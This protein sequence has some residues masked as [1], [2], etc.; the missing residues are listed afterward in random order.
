MRALPTTTPILGAFA[1]IAGVLHFSATNPQTISLDQI[2]NAF[3]G[4][5]SAVVGGGLYSLSVSGFQP[6]AI[7]LRLNPSQDLPT[8]LGGVEVTFDGVPAAILLTSPGQIIVAPP[9][10]LPAQTNARGDDT[11]RPH[12][13]G[14]TIFT[15]VQLSYNG[16]FSNAAW[17]PV[18]S[19]LPGLLSDNFPMLSP[20]LANF[21][22]GNVRNQDGVQNDAEHPAAAGSTIRS[23]SPE[24]ASLSPRVLPV[25]L[26]LRGYSLPCQLSI[27]PGLII[28][29]QICLERTRR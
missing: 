13:S 12:L 25:R 26:R 5:S 15:S 22:D 8:E 14:E 1:T 7:D 19:Q 18:S 17:I 23:S 16:V 24:W 27:R 11:A 20:D 28:R 4:D 21:P 9:W 2:S 10:N 6:P 3:S 29:K